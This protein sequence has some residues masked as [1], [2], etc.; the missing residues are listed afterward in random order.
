MALAVIV[1]SAM[2]T[3]AN[4]YAKTVFTVGHFPIRAADPDAMWSRTM[5]KSLP[6]KL[7]PLR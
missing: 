2:M 6:Y 3:W 5:K 7:H 1:L 4:A